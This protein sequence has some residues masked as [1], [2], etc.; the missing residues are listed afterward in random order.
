M[1]KPAY[2]FP[3]PIALAD[4]LCE[5]IEQIVEKA[6]HYCSNGKTPEGWLCDINSTYSLSANALD[7]FPI[8]K[9]Q[10]LIAATEYSMLHWKKDCKI[11]NSWVNVAQSYQYQE[12]HHHLTGGK[13]QVKFCAVYYPQVHQTEVITFHSP[14]V[15]IVTFTGGHGSMSIN[16]KPNRLIL[17]PAYLEHS[18]RSIKREVDKISFSANFIIN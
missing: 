6:Y 5:D 10:I 2:I 17:F 4:D 3:T 12:Q 18:F 13:D 1:I 8:L 16:I 11:I 14:F 7:D 15:S 9:Q